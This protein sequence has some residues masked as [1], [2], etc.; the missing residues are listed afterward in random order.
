MLRHIRKPGDLE[1]FRQVAARVR[2]F[3]EMFA[4]GLFMIGFPGETFGQMMDTFRFAG[5]LGLDWSGIATCQAIRGA[6]LFE[7]FEEVFRS[8][9]NSRGA[10]VRNYVPVRQSPRD[11]IEVSAGTVRGASVFRL[12]PDAVPSPDQ[13]KEIWFAFNLLSNY[14]CNHNLASGGRPEKFIAWVEAAQVPYPANPYMSLFLALAHGLGGREDR[15]EALRRRA[16]EAA[17][18][19]YWEERFADFGL[20]DVLQEFPRTPA[21]VLERLGRLRARWVP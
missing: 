9:M 3:P 13:I 1:T 2:R 5:E 20:D 16:A 10:S 17:R 14:I 21:D 12:P 6:G 19:A 15:A 11:E 8:Q 4:V 7:D 18:S